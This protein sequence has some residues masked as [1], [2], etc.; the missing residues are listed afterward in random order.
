MV[1]ALWARVLRPPPW[2][3]VLDAGPSEV[4][5]VQER[6]VA[7]MPPAAAAVGLASGS[8]APTPAPD[9]DGMPRRGGKLLRFAPSADSDGAPDSD[10]CRYAPKPSELAAR[11]KEPGPCAA[12]GADNVGLLVGDIMLPLRSGGDAGKVLTTLLSSDVNRV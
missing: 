4:R 1:S 6:P 2:L 9:M 12:V 5:L 8:S 11:D 7:G 3:P 10:C